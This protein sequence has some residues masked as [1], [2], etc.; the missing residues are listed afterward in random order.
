MIHVHIS[1]MPPYFGFRIAPVHKPLKAPFLQSELMLC[2]KGSLQGK[3]SGMSVFMQAVG[4]TSLSF[5]GRL[6]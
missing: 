5:S 1:E 6:A 4:V 2:S 3:A